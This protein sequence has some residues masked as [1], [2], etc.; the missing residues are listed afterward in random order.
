MLVASTLAGAA[1]EHQTL[2]TLCHFGP[3]PLDFLQSGSPVSERPVE[4]G[5]SCAAV[6]LPPFAAFQTEI[7]K[8]SRKALLAPCCSRPARFWWHS[9][10]CQC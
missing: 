7:G 1:V 8:S 6:R 5:T 4:L 2:E 9:G 10:V 3:R